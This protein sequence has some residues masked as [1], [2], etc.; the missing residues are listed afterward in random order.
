MTGVDLRTVQELLGHQTPAMTLRYA[1]LSPEHQY[2][3]VQRLVCSP[4][5]TTSATDGKPAK[6]AANGPA[7]VRVLP[8]DSSGGARSRT[9]DLGIMSRL[10]A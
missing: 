2:A 7:E 9:A 8:S 3:A 6:V 10:A 5:A 1:H 4:S